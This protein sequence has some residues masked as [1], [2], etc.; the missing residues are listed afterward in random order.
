MAMATWLRKMGVILTTHTGTGMIL[1]VPQK[2]F[3]KM[4]G[5]PHPSEKYAQGKLDHFARDRDEN[6]KKMKPPHGLT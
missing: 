3:K 5:F 2:T 1:Q 4:V 6:K